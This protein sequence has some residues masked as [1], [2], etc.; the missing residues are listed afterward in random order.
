MPNSNASGN[1]TTIRRR[2]IRG[3]SNLPQ[4][5]T[6]A[7]L[8]ITGTVLI[9]QLEGEVTTL[10]QTQ[11][12]N[13][14]IVATPTIGAATD[15]CAVTD[16]SAAA[17]GTHF[18]LPGVF[19]TALPRSANGAHV[20]PS[21][22]TV[23]TAGTVGLSASASSTGQYKLNCIWEALSADGNVTATPAT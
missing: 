6:A 23:V 18:N 12:N 16:F 14:K 10:F 17:V 20:G 5:A 1:L 13:L 9:H 15:L 11:L 19:A 8:T 2:T 7:L 21:A 22:V 4:T 3:A